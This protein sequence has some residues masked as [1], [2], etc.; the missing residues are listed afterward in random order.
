ME[1]FIRLW[2]DSG[3]YHLEFGQFTMLLVGCLLLF[4]AIRKGFEPLLLVPIGFGC[5]LANIPG[6]GMSLS[7]VDNALD[8]RYPEVIAAIASA[9]GQEAQLGAQAL[10]TA[11]KEAPA[12]M[13]AEAYRLATDLGYSHGV[14]YSF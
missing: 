4:L 5:M 11:W 10:V 7:S 8:S 2:H 1:N 6:A 9:L 12:G 3:I 14:L 13:Q